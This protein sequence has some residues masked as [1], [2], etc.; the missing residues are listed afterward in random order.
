M[1]ATTL[2]SATATAD[3]AA[4]IAATVPVLVA[5]VPFALLLGALASERGLSWAETGLMSG[6]VFV[7]SSQFVVLNAWTAPPAL[8]AIVIAA[9]VVNLRHVFMS[10]SIRRKLDHWPR[11]VRPLALLFLADE[12]WAFAE[13]RAARGRLSLAYY[14]GLALPLYLAWLTATVA[15]VAL[16]SFIR[17]PK[18]FGFDFAFIAIFIGLIVGFR[19]QPAA[20]VTALAAGATAALCH[21]VAPGA[22]SIAAGAVAGMLAAALAYRPGQEAG[23]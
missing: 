22:W 8:A 13:A 17:D 18:L 21:L 16:G 10:A 4:G 5:E 23:R 11:W 14:A 2:P 19:T 1:T 20:A 9:F 7:G 6:L 3:F 12:I 15:G